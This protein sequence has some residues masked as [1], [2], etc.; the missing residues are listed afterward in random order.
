MGGIISLY[1]ICEYP[2]TFGG[3]GCLSTHWL[4]LFVK[5]ATIPLA[6]FEYLSAHVPDPGTHR[7]YFD[8][9]TETLDA[10][11][12]ESQAFADMLFREKG[13]GDTNF[14]S[15]VYPGAAHEENSWAKRVSVPLVFLSEH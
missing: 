2:G 9:G 13:Y 5:N 4:G 8:H 7:I 10:L 11:Y 1:A 3:A 14:M 15:R 6:E 12:G